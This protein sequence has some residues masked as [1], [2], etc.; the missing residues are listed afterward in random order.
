MMTEQE[1][2]QK[3]NEVLADEF[4]ADAST[5][6]PDAMLMETLELDSLDLVDVVVLINKNFGV[7]LV[8]PDFVGIKTFQDFY[9]LII[10]KV[11]E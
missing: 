4:E 2:I 3:I 8:G 6:T 11:N 9:N 10:K 5:I 1:I 7:T